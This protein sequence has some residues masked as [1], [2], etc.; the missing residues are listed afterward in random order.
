MDL[1]KPFQEHPYIVGLLVV[2]VLVACG[3]GV[4]VS[5][6][7]IS[8]QLANTGLTATAA[9]QF[10]AVSGE[11][12]A[13]TP[14]PTV[15]DRTISEV[16]Q[17]LVTPT[18]IVIATPILPVETATSA[19]TPASTPTPIPIEAAT[20]TPIPLAERVTPTPIEIPALPKC[21]PNGHIAYFYVPVVGGPIIGYVDP[22]V[23][24]W[25]PVIGQTIGFWQVTTETWVEK[26]YCYGVNT[27]DVRWLDPTP[28]YHLIHP[29]P[30][31]PPHR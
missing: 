11:E 16:R 7:F 24:P 20:A 19:V 1:V 26:V 30:N 9:A 8:P 15:V 2:L 31:P 10:A 29:Y 23:D 22:A 13:I 5:S 27:E 25:L 18:G 17:P 14:S 3:L 6:L 4:F 28:T 21:I 12:T